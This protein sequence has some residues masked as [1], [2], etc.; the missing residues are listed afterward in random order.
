MSAALANLKLGV[1]VFAGGTHGLTV[2]GPGWSATEA[3]RVAE[4]L[5]LLVFASNEAQLDTAGIASVGRE[6]A[7]L[8]QDRRPVATCLVCHHDEAGHLLDYIQ[9]PHDFVTEARR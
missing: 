9:N 2:S 5:E 7:A 4:L 3:R 6:L 1:R 8:L